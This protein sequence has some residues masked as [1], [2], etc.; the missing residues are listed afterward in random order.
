M[1][2]TS[3]KVVV[4]GSTSNLG[5]GFDTLGLALRLYTRVRLTPRAGTQLTLST[6]VGARERAGAEEMIRGTADLFFRESG[7]KPFGFDLAIHGDV[8]VARGLGFSA[9]VRVGVLAGLNKMSGARL[10][11]RRLLE[12][13]TELEGHPD[14]ASPSIF[15]GFTVSGWVEGGVR[16]FRFAVNQKWRFVTLIPRFRVSTEQ[17]REL[18]PGTYSKEVAHH[19]LNRAAL[20]TAG[21]ASG[22]PEALRGI[23]DDRVHQP[24]RESL[25]RQ[26]YP[27]IQAGQE[28]GA[29]GGFLSGSGSAIICLG[30][31]NL[32]RIA[33][34]MQGQLPD[35]EIRILRAENR[36]FR[37]G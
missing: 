13:A 12:L 4:P 16:C 5:S 3:V 30:L 7:C 36:G 29:I 31:K 37:L 11:R 19:G 17:A 9:S 10:D 8:P 24:F 15:G 21:F 1:E 35:S 2:R 22:K 25:V 18:V 27:V 20:L 26:L 34:A 23:F 33:V 14:N 6:A 28:A 32:E